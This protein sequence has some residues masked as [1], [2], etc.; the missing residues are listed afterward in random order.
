MMWRKLLL[1]CLAMALLLGPLSAS[2]LPSSSPP[3]AIS[4]VEDQMAAALVE[5]RAALVRSNEEIATQSR[6]LTRLWLLTG[7]LAATA[8]LEATAILL[9]K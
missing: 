6:Q 2:P 8:A 4:S 1:G 9:R 3:S 5:A 7:A